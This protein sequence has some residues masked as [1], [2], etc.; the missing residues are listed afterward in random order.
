MEVNKSK[1]TISYERHLDRAVLKF[2]NSRR[3]YPTIAIGYPIPNKEE[4]LELLTTAV[5]VPDHGKLEPWRLIVIEQSAMQH[6]AE[7]LIRRGAELEKSKSLV[8]KA[9]EVFSGAKLIVAVIESP[10]LEAKIPLIE[11]TLSAGAV[12]LSLVNAALTSGWGAAWVTGFGAHDPKFR[13]TE[14]GLKKH[15]RVAGFIHIGTSSVKPSERPRPNIHSI[16]TWLTE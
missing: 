1:N 4:L 11:Q 12:C 16:T 5:R 3:S 15:E 7:S 6:L 14:L 9:A 10:D 13:E 8:Q 2:L